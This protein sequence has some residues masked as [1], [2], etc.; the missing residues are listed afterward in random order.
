MLTAIVLASFVCIKTS[1]FG[2]MYVNPSIFRS[3]VTNHGQT[4]LKSCPESGMGKCW[5]LGLSETPIVAARRLNGVILDCRNLT[6]LEKAELAV[7]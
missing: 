5:A 3:L 7:K 1:D 4:W 6:E 2:D